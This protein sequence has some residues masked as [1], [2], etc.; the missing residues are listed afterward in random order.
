MATRR[1]GGADL[2]D[3][4]ARL[5]FSEGGGSGDDSTEVSGEVTA[6]S[7]DSGAVV[8]VDAEPLSAGDEGVRTP[9]VA[10]PPA[11]APAFKPA[12]A[13]APRPAAPAPAPVAAPASGSAEDYSKAVAEDGPISFA[14]DANAVEPGLKAPGAGSTM[15]LI[16][17]AVVC[18][19]VG[20]VLGGFASSTNSARMLVN[21]QSSG[22]QTVLT[23]LEPAG[24]R[25]AELSSTLAG[26]AIETGYPEAFD[27]AL[28]TAYGENAPVL[29]PT[30]LVQAGPLLTHDPVV[31]RQ[32]ITFAIR[33]QFVQSLVGSHLRRT[34]AD[35]NEI[36][37][38]LEAG[39][40]TRGIGI[41]FEFMAGAAAYNA[42]L[43]DPTQPF[44]PPGGERIEYDTLEL[45]IVTN[46]ADPTQSYS[47]YN[48][49]TSRGDAIQIPPHDIV[50]LPREQ[51][52]PAITG[53]TPLSRYRARAEQLR[54]EISAVAAEQ[55]AIAESLRELANRPQLTTF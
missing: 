25:L 38:E 16:V 24:S 50:L 43:A 9:A 11:Q 18:I 22:A 4:K 2:D 47:V 42:W 12:L 19:V 20:L 17:T 8:D 6:A 41:A 30:T 49:F 23:A 55:A 34:D 35:M 32:L 52:L 13:P 29:E 37:R 3:L 39:S 15:P 31:S 36:R 53:E 45:T 40:Q 14:L 5:G 33:T 7:D 46:P 51:L 10:A 27:Q 54:E 28:R 21:R 44:Q 26:V 1:R 48:V